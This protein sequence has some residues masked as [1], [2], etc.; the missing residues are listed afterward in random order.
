[1]KPERNFVAAGRAAQ[2]AQELLRPRRVGPDPLAALAPLADG[3]APALA[4]ALAPLVGGLAP[5]VTHDAGRV[6]TFAELTND[7]TPLTAHLAFAGGARQVL[8]TIDGSAIL[9]MVDRAFGGRG[10]TPTVLPDALP[11]LAKLMIGRIEAALTLAFSRIPGLEGLEPAPTN[12]ASG[13]TMLGIVVLSIAEEAGAVW[14][15]AIA[16]PLADIAGTASPTARAARD[17][18]SDARGALPLALNAELARSRLPLSMIAALQPGTFVPLTMPRSVALKAGSTTIAR[19]SI[20][21][22]DERFA[23]RLTTVF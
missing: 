19:G 6:A 8:A 12:A 18:N 15:L 17:F 4:E 22:V 7:A 23:L 20:G 5:R 14:P 2:H 11:L 16:L 10:E 21:D 13:D 1:M 3:L 9:R